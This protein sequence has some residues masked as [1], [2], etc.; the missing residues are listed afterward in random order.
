M[1]KGGGSRRLTTIRS[2]DRSVRERKNFLT[3][4]NDLPGLTLTSFYVGAFRVFKV[5]IHLDPVGSQTQQSRTPA[6]NR[7]T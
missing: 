3:L 1:K 6:L 7:A 4:N 2:F 5:A